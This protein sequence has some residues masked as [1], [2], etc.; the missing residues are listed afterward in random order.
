MKSALFM[1][2]L[3]TNAQPDSARVRVWWEGS[4]RSGIFGRKLAAAR[5]ILEYNGI[6]LIYGPAA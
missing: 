1:Y 3:P 6:L 5:G 4:K 2:Q